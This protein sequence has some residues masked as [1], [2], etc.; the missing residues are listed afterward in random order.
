MRSGTGGRALR[1]ALVDQ[2]H[3]SA[4]A[5]AAASSAVDFVSGRHP[6]LFK[7]AP[8]VRAY[9][10][11]FGLGGDVPLQPI[12]TLSG[13]LRVRVMLADAFAGDAPPHVLLLD[14]PTNHLD[15]ET[16]TA[17]AAALETFTGAIITVSHNCAFL[18]ALCR[19]LW[20][21]EKKLGSPE[22]PNCVTIKPSTESAD[23]LEHFRAFAERIV[24]RADRPHIRSMLTVRFMRHAALVHHAGALAS[25]VV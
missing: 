22:S 14:E 5:A 24:P 18:L 6:G 25:L 11:R 10:A 20:I 21:T 19:E 15:A 8:T 7:D 4:L 16:I 2:N 13:G 12:E 23:F 1:V 17:L 9:L 3:L